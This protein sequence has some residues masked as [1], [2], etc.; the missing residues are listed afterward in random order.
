V[1]AARNQFLFFGNLG[2][3][4]IGLRAGCAMTSAKPGSVPSTATTVRARRR[5]PTSSA[6]QP[7]GLAAT[8]VTDH[9]AINNSGIVVN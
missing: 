7:G 4:R 3:D 6:G 8:H 1:A 5:H 9:A 2:Y